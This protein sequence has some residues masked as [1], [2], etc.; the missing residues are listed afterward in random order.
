M[1]RDRWDILSQGRFPGVQRANA[2]QRDKG[3]RVAKPWYEEH[4]DGKR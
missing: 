3:R 1:G 4:R 2:V